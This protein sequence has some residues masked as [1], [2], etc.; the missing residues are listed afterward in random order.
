MQQQDL[1]P[2][3]GWTI[4]KIRI[5][6]W[7][8]VPYEDSKEEHRGES[9]RNR[10]ASGIEAGVRNIVKAF[11]TRA[12]THKRKSTIVEQCGEYLL[13]LLGF[14][15]LCLF[16][17]FLKEMVPYSFDWGEL[18]L[19]DITFKLWIVCCEDVLRM[20]FHHF[21]ANAAG[22]CR[23]GM[24]IFDMLLQIFFWFK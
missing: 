12:I 2:L 13:I 23:N 9:L 18:F 3:V 22:C 5:C 6:C 21:L 14:Q 11:T 19:T 16:L 8:M 10:G 15:I 17:M 1:C 20:V 4:S 24:N 7:L